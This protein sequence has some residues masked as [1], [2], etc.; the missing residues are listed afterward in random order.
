MMVLKGLVEQEKT[1]GK[2]ERWWGQCDNQCDIQCDRH[3]VTVCRGPARK[4]RELTRDVRKGKE[5]NQYLYKIKCRKGEVCD[6]LT[7]EKCESRCHQIQ[8]PANSGV[9]VTQKCP[10]TRRGKKHL[11]WV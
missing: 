1:R 9:R 3:S 8:A 2:R 7:E 6:T 4:Q 5:I 10:R 11:E